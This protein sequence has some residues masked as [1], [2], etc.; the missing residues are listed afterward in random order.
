MPLSEINLLKVKTKVKCGVSSFE[1][2]EVKLQE[3]TN[4]GK[5]SVSSF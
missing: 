4:Y 3:I 5:S 1:L 2:T